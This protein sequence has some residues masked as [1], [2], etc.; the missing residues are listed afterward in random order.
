MKAQNS[1]WCDHST[2]LELGME[3]ETLI[4]IGT[5]IRNVICSFIL[6]TKIMRKCLCSAQ[7]ISRKDGYWQQNMR[8]MSRLQAVFQSKDNF[9]KNSVTVRWRGSGVHAVF[10]SYWRFYNAGCGI[11]FFCTSLLIPKRPIIAD[12]GTHYAVICDIRIISIALRRKR[13]CLMENR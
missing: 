2:V 3:I 5:E 7:R 11:P 8:L 1:S 9:Q 12:S 4:D 10:D 13:V 6:I